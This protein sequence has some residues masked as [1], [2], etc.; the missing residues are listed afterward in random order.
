MTPGASAATLAVPG[1]LNLARMRWRMALAKNAEWLLLDD[2]SILRALWAEGRPVVARVTAAAGAGRRGGTGELVEAV[3]IEAA[4]GDPA[5]RRA[6]LAALAHCLSLA[7][8]PDGFY[9][10]AERDRHLAPLVRRYRGLRV[11]CDADPFE[12]AVKAIAG[13]QVHMALAG[14]LVRRLAAAFGAP[15]EVPRTWR[16][17]PPRLLAAFPRPEALASADPDDLVPMGFTRQK[18][19][20]IVELA[21]RIAAGRLDFAQLFALPD[22]EAIAALTTLPGVGPWTAE[23]VLLFGLGR[24]DVFPA[25]DAGLRA[26]LARQL[27][28]PSRPTPEAAARLGEAWRPHRSLAALY[29]W[30]TL[31]DPDL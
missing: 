22:E 20:A 26:A 8:P 30:E 6:A 25:A 28:L 23:C 15:V 10:M 11:V 2:G 31:H 12:S 27:C 7:R 5:V 18:A 1:G 14:A 17:E 24:P 13:Q 29:L 16:A 9:A 19:N 21:R 4:T 3:T